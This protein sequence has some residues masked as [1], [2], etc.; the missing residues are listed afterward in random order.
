MRDPKRIKRM[1]SLIG[2]LWK[3]KPD[4]RF[5]QLIN[6]IEYEFS[7]QNNGF[8]HRRVFEKDSHNLEQPFSYMDLFYLE[9]DKFETFLIG[10]IKDYKNKK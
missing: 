3:K 5:F 4:M 9:D 7:K 1:L 10:F 8:G 6:W 2:E